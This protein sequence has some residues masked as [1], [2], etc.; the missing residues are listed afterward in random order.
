MKIGFIGAGNM[1]KAII[2][3]WVARKTID[4][5]DILIHSAHRN[6]YESYANRMGIKAYST[7]SDLVRDAD[8]IFM[9][10][11][12]FILASVIDEIKEVVTEKKLIISMASGVSLAE[13]N[14]CF[15]DN[16]EIPTIRIMPNVNVEINEGMTAFVRNKFVSDIIYEQIK[17]L[18]DDLGRTLEMPEKDFSIF[19]A[20]AG[21]SPAYVYY[22]I[23]AMARSG[24]KYGLTKKEATEI[25]A[26]AVLGSAQKVL[27]GTKSPMDMVDDVCSPGGTTIAGLLAMEE[28]GF[29]TA[30]VKGIDA[31]VLKDQ[32]TH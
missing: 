30:V 21:S 20:L 26:Q 8:I 23:D 3:G 25:A 2:D 12:P 13:I 28:A 6:N 15:G 5:K 16:K 22:F 29:L 18:F 10:V 4:T 17:S 9:A 11:K 31:T 14:D 24:V 1:A 32:A 27:V 7:N 19:V